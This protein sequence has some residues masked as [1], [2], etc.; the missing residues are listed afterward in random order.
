MAS[1]SV[2]GSSK[3]YSG[4]E[5]GRSRV[6]DAADQNQPPMCDSTASTQ[7]RSLPIF[8]T[9]TG[10]GTFPLRNPGI[11]TD[12]ERSF[13][14]CSTA[15]SSSCGDTSTVRRTRFSPSSST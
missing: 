11:L 2:V 15:C 6:R 7:I 9:S 12:S 10:I 13:T 8:E 1:L 14:A 3:S 4:G 5:I